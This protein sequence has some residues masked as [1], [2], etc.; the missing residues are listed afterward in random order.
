M[1]K[2]WAGINEL[3]R[4]KNKFSYINQIQIGNNTINDPKLMANA[5]NNFFANVGPNT[6]KEIP[7]T[8]ISPLDFLKNRVINN[9]CLKPTTIPEVMTIVLKLDESKSAGPSDIPIYVLRIAAALIVPH[10]VSI[11]NSSFETGIFPDIS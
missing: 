10:L 7:R 6:D 8:P 2:N 3:I 1:K 9:F 4:S 5:F 11:F